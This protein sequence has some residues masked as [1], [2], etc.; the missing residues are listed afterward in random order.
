M[1]GHQTRQTHLYL[2]T[3]KGRTTQPQERRRMP[4]SIAC[5][6][7]QMRHLTDEE[8]TRSLLNL[9]FILNRMPYHAASLSLVL[10]GLVAEHWIAQ[11]NKKQ[12]GDK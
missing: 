9:A 1:S 11:Q 3:S 5:K 8:K 12:A 2:A 6:P 4:T 7:A 10:D